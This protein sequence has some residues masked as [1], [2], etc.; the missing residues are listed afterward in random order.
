MPVFPEP[1]ARKA[2]GDADRRFAVPPLRPDGGRPRRRPGRQEPPGL[3][4]GDPVAPPVNLRQGGHAGL[5][6]QSR[7]TNRGQWWAHCCAAIVVRD[8]GTS[9]CASYEEAQALW[10]WHVGRG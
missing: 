5:I 6:Q 1:R 7:Y 9:W 2:P 10:R 3:T 4:S 8:D